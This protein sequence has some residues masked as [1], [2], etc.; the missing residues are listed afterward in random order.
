MRKRHNEEENM[1]KSNRAFWVAWNSIQMKVSKEFANEEWDTQQ[2][3]AEVELFK[4]FC[5]SFFSSP[6]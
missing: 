3:E 4:K 5:T 6:P 2:Y 1:A